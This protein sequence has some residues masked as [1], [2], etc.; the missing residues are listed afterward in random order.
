VGRSPLA[1]D[2]LFLSYQFKCSFPCNNP[3][4][5]IDPRNHIHK[6]SGILLLPCTSPSQPLLCCEGEGA[7]RQSIWIK[8]YLITCTNCGHLKKELNARWQV[9]NNDFPFGAGD[10]LPL[11]Q[12]LLTYNESLSALNYELNV[13]AACHFNSLSVYPTRIVGTQKRNYRT[14]IFSFANTAQRR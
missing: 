10:R 1:N 13:D 12:F 14:D 11:T 9:G 4:R 5:I 7:F 8:G 6:L 3:S 2:P